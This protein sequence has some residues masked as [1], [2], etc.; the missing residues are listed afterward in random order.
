MLK[1]ALCDDDITFHRIIEKSLSEFAMNFPDDIRSFYFCSGDELL[2]SDETFDV[3]LLDV[4]MP[5]RSG[6]EI[7]K[8]LNAT[9]S[10]S[11]II[12]V[13][14]HS[15]VYKEGFKVNAFRFVTKPLNRSELF[16]AL[17]SAF[18]SMLGSRVLSLNSKKHSLTS[19]EKNI[20]YIM[21][22]DSRTI[23]FLQDNSVSSDRSLSAWIKLLDPRLFAKTHKSFIVNFEAIEN[24]ENDHINLYTGDII[25]ISRRLYSTFIEG[26]LN[27]DLNFR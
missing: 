21:A 26:Y 17:S 16:E 14:S 15:E 4:D 11:K 2:N 27:Y 18:S 3:I 24:I 22:D 8:R 23:V 10:P 13:T 6:I 1:I 19:L 7:A 9:H 20:K 5:A 12:L 25:P